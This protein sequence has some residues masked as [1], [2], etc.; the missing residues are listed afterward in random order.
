M[1]PAPSGDLLREVLIYNTGDY[2]RN[3]LERD[4]PRAVPSQQEAVARH[5]GV[6]VMNRNAFTILLRS[7]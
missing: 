1:S 5:E 6:P 2:P 3:T 7:A 4:G